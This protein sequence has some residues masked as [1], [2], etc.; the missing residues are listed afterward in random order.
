MGEADLLELLSQDMRFNLE[1][2]QSSSDQCH[3]RN[4]VRSVFAYIDA[5]LLSLR[6]Q[7]LSSVIQTIPDDEEPLKRIVPLLENFPRL[8][9][10]GR[11][12]VE[13]NKSAFVPLVAYTLKVN[14]ELNGFSKDVLSS[15]LWNDFR[16]AVDI[17]NRI[18]H[19]KPDLSMDISDEDLTTIH[20]AIEWWDSALNASK[21]E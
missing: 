8:K 4:Y 5:S 20:K 3:R 12:E 21:S 2:V 18:T 6:K 11:M 1:L 19:P 13:Y 7:V 16:N 9:D 17:R 10:N 14:A 15:N